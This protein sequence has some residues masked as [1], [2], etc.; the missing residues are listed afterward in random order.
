[1]KSEEDEDMREDDEESFTDSLFFETKCN[2]CMGVSRTHVPVLL[3]YA[4]SLLRNC[5]NDCV[6]TLHISFVGMS[7]DGESVDVLNHMI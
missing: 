2:I 1:M 4:H 6:S 7:C 5:I 3:P